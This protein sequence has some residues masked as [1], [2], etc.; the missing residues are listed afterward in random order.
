MKSQYNPKTAR[1]F[2]LNRDGSRAVSID[3]NG[4]REVLPVSLDGETIQT[5]S[6]LYWE[7]CGNF[8]FPVIRM[9]GKAVTVYPD[10]EVECE[11]WLPYAVKYP[12]TA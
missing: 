9:K 8:A 7:Q 10:S 5:R 4:N 11:K 6:V 2:Y 3:H 12:A 1:V